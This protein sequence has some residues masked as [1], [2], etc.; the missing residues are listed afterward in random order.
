[1]GG[2]GGLLEARREGGDLGIRRGRQGLGQ[3][4][5]R[6]RASPGQL[7]KRRLQVQLRNR[8]AVDPAQLTLRGLQDRRNPL[9]PEAT[10]ARRM[11]SGAKSRANSG[12]IPPPSR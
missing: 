8:P 1:M 10:L 7:P 4:V 6:E 2:R 11:G 3:G 12:K 5:V 9:Q